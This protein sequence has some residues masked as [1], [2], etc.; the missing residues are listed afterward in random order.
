MIPQRITSERMCTRLRTLAYL[1][2]SSQH[3][4]LA[5]AKDADNLRPDVIDVQ[6]IFNSSRGGPFNFT[7][8]FKVFA[9]KLSSSVRK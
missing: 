6:F 1:L 3:P 8:A 7:K 4:T 2:R 5:L 9:P